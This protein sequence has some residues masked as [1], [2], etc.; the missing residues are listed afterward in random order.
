MPKRDATVT[1]GQSTGP[2]GREAGTGRGMGQ[3]SGRKGRGGVNRQGSDPRG[4]CLCPRCGKTIDHQA[5]TPCYETICPQCGSK[6][7]REWR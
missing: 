6:M 3:G 5:G 2:G 7:I 1:R 4:N